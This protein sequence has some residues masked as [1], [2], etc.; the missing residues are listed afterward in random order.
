MSLLHIAEIIRKRQ[1]VRLVRETSRMMNVTVAMEE[2][3]ALSSFVTT[4]ARNT[5]VISLVIIHRSQNTCNYHYL[6]PK[7]RQNK[8]FLFVIQINF[9]TFVANYKIIYYAE[10]I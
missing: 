8:A 5:A 7:K 10:R 9:S 1:D 2:T 3:D 6:T 4:G